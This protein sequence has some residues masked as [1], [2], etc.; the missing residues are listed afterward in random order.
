LLGEGDGGGETAVASAIAHAM[1]A[2]SNQV[3]RTMTQIDKLRLFMICLLKQMN[4]PP[5]GQE[6]MNKKPDTKMYRA[7]EG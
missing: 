5:K 7:G 6:A 4:Y 1:P 3:A 2:A